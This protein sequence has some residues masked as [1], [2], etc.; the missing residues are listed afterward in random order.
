MRE[1]TGFNIGAWDYGWRHLPPYDYYLFLQDD[2]F[3]VRPL[4]KSLV[5]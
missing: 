2:C 5:Y 3:I 4:L 1:N